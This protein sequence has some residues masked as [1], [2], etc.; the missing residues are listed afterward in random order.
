MDRLNLR[1]IIDIQ[2]EMLIKTHAWGT[3]GT[4]KDMFR[5]E[6]HVGS[7]QQTVF[8]VMRLC[9]V[10]KGTSVYKDMNRYKG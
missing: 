9:D 5:I 1:Y 4:F 7:H 6:I 2:I 3:E 10:T 8:K